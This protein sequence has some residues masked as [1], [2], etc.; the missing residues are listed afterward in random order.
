[1]LLGG[2]AVF[3]G[4]V[5]LSKSFAQKVSSEARKVINPRYAYVQDVIK[6]N[7]KGKKRRQKS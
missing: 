2:C 4:L 5:P 6:E 3:S 1:M 7:K